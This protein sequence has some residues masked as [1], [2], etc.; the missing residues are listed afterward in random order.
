LK[1]YKKIR[2][3]IVGVKGGN[4]F[5]ETQV[6]TAVGPFNM[7]SNHDLNDEIIQPVTPPHLYGVYCIQFDDLAQSDQSEWN[8]I[9]IAV[10]I[11]YRCKFWAD[12]KK[13]VDQHRRFSGGDDDTIWG[14]SQTTPRAWLHNLQF[15]NDDP[16]GDEH[17]WPCNNYRTLG[18]AWPGE[19][20]N[21]KE[22][23]SAY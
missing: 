15:A 23:I 19:F 9:E 11:S 17:T 14:T 20:L 3:A 22:W 21:I 4:I 12:E 16:S 10:D 7:G 2:K 6:A 5:T 18:N 1:I 8:L 13:S